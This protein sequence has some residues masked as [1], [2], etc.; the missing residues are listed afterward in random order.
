MKSNATGIYLPNGGF[1]RFAETAPKQGKQIAT[2]AT[3][4]GISNV[5]SALPNP[6]P[7]L[8]KLGKSIQAYRDLRSDGHVGGCIRRRKAAVKSLQSGLDRNL[9][10]SRHADDITD[11]L[12][13]LDMGRIVSE[14]LDAPLYGYQPLEVVWGKVGNY[15]VPVDV[16]GKPAEWYFFDQQNRL[17]FK[18]KSAGQDGELLPE[19]SHLLPRQD[20][21]YD[22]PYG[23][24]DLARCFWPTKFKQGGIDFWFKFVEKYGTPWLVGKAPRSTPDHEIDSLLDMLEAMVQDAVAVIPDDASVEIVEA[25]GKSSSADVF[26]KFLMHLRSEVS[27]ALLGQ[28]QTTEADTT[29]ASAQAGQDVS[30]DIRDADAG[31]VAA[32]INQLI[33]W[34]AE[35]NFNDAPPVF[36]FWEPE[37]VD[38]TLAERD[39]ILKNA[40]ANLTR[41]YFKRA[42]QLQDDDIGEAPAQGVNTPFAFAEGQ[43]NSYPD[44]EAIDAAVGGLSNVLLNDQASDLLTPVITAMQR[45]QSEAEMLGLL[46]EAYPHMNDDALVNTLT[47]MLFIADTWGRLSANANRID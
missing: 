15:I 16:I 7:V 45:G 39:A 35:L 1:V 27:I 4:A 10:P 21:S 19:R 20:A 31:L 47:N 36:S 43:P 41:Q 14:I 23:V 29:N 3:A 25:G 38:K 11:I 12:A 30:A 26:E 2:R 24:P 33:G 28:N 44:Q 37:S 17:R 42:Y 22:N 9:E 18:S 5:G 8:R 46:A 13:D 34:I 40:G 32:T 6:D